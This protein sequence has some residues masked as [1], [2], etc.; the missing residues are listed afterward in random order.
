MT[1]RGQTAAWIARRPGV[2]VLSFDQRLVTLRL[3]SGTVD[4]GS[5][6]WRWGPEVSGS[7]RRL[8][9]AA[10]NGAFKFSTNSGGFMS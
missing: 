3:H 7:E 10:F 9:V 2:A 5:S 6:G 1:W 8:V 4:A